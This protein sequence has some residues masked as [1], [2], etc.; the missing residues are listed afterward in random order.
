M[1]AGR[2]VQRHEHVGRPVARELRADERDVRP[3]LR[4]GSW[5]GIGPARLVE[6]VSSASEGTAGASTSSR[7]DADAMRRR[8]EGT[9]TLTPPGRSKTPNDA[10]CAPER[11]PP[12]RATA[13]APPPS[14]AIRRASSITRS[15][16]RSSGILSTTSPFTTRNPCPLPAAMPRSASRLARPVHHASHHRD[17]DRD[18]EALALDRLVHLLRE[19]EDVHLRAATARARHEVEPAPAE[20]ERLE[21]PRA[22]LDLLDRVVGERD[23]DRVPDPFR[24]ERPDADGALHAAH[25]H[26]AGLGHAEVQRVVARL[27]EQTVRLDHHARIR[28]LH[29][30]LDVEEALLEDARLVRRAL[31]ER[32]GRRR[33]V[34]FEQ[35]LLERTGVHADPDRTL[36]A[37]PRARS[38][39]PCPGT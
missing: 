15:T 31:D 28:V 12:G 38:V 19:P 39:A 7:T 20:P 11:Q 36:R 25:R 29:R 9:G 13:R 18:L 8:G 10:R 6:P 1:S 16:N 24:E 27:G 30:D 34:A 35:V 26:R 5:C 2:S 37:W 4:V 14:A 32:L 21:D 17:P 23:A 22:D 3:S 33:A